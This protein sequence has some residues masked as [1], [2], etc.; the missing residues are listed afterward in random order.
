MDER[1]SPSTLQSFSSSQPLR[2][3]FPI[4]LISSTII[5]SSSDRNSDHLIFSD[6]IARLCR[7]AL[8]NIRKI[9]PFLPEQVAPLLVQIFVI[10]RLHIAMLFWPDFHH[11]QSDLCKWSRMQYPGLQSAQESTRHTS[12]YF[13]ALGTSCGSHLIQEID[14]CT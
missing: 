10:F 11:V 2:Q 14:A 8:C 4:Q 13:S 9:R 7:F 6:H 12:I 3:H 1:K 5:Q